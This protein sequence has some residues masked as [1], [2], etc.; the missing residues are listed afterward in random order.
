MPY[1]G[2]L[3]GLDD[4]VGQVLKAVRESGQEENTLIFFISD[5]G[6]PQQGN[7]SNNTPLSGDK[8]TVLEGG[9]R[10][11]YHCSGKERSRPVRFTRNRYLARHPC[12]GSSIAGQHRLVPPIVPWTE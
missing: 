4:A 5:N 6:G 9:I 12:H 10:V 7:G 2:L 8:G 11:P 1:A 3:S